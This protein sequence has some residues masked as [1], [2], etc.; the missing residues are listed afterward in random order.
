M[1]PDS[2][3]DPAA[4]ATVAL[5]AVWLVVHWLRIGRP[6]AAQR[7]CSRCD[8]NLLEPGSSPPAAGGVRSKQLRVIG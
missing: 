2:L 1:L 3:H 4:L 5:A 8:H 7:G 6:E